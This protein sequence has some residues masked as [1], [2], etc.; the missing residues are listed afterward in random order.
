MFL[1]FISIQVPRLLAVSSSLIISELKD[2]AAILAKIMEAFFLVTSC[3]PYCLLTSTS[4]AVRVE[5]FKLHQ[6]ASKMDGDF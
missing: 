3:N 2:N 4:E 6:A 5:L 1:S